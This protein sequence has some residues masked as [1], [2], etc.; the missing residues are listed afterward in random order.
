MRDQAGMSYGISGD[1]RMARRI[2]ETG[3][4]ED[5]DYPMNYYNLA[6]A[7]AGEKNLS[8]ARTHLQQAF[9]R[10]ANMNPG[11]KM[12]IAAEDDSFLPYKSNKEFWTFIERLGG[13]K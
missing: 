4:A 2:F 3:S 1:L 10:K 6:C 13:G 11:E 8:D 7:D 9:D 5:P 12:P